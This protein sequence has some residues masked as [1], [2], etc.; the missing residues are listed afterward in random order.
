MSGIPPDTKNIG[1]Y[2]TKNRTLQGL[3]LHI[4]D[5]LQWENSYIK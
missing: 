1:K 3:D 4:Q 5:T 2:P